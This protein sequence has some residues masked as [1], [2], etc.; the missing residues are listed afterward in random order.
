MSSNAASAGP[1]ERPVGL[2][3]VGPTASGKTAL[4]IELAR[5]LAGEIISMDSRQVY[6]RMDVGTAKATPDEQAAAPH[7][8]FDLVEPDERFSAGRFA[9]YAR[10]RIADIEARGRV[11][12]L[13]GG[14]GFFLSALTR[15]LFREPPLDDDRR[16]ALERALRDVDDETLRAYVEA[17]D[18][19][20]AASLAQGGGRQR[21]LRA[22]EV[23]LLT[24]RALSWWHEHAPPAEAPL[25]FLTVLL[26][27]ERVELDRRIDARVRAMIDAGLVD[28]V[29][30][31]L[32]DG[33][34]PDA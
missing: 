21:M 8:G 13:V 23:A 32:D 19:R 6:R 5:A 10:A 11:P 17:L 1:A 20:T 16:R 3:L 31:L 30:A 2:A 25:R 33:V 12:I 4:S 22:L 9:G 7:H 14:T 24:G 15:P 28:E 29:R 18:P 27:L 34:R 26:D